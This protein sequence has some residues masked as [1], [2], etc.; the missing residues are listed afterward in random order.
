[1]DSVGAAF[2]C[3]SVTYPFSFKSSEGVDHN[4]AAASRTYVTLLTI[5]LTVCY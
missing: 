5:S 1:M 2:S 3:A 4:R